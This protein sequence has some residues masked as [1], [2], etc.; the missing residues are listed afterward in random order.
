MGMLKE[1]QVEIRL[2]IIILLSFLFG[3]LIGME[4]ESYLDASN[5]IDIICGSRRRY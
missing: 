3:Y 5:A 4:A 2:G 1:K